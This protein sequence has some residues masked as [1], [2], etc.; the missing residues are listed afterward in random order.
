METTCIFLTHQEDHIHTDT[1]LAYCD[2]YRQCLQVIV[3]L[4]P[5]CKLLLLKRRGSC[6][7]KRKLCVR[8][9][10]HVYV[11]ERKR[12]FCVCM[13]DRGQ[14]RVSFSISFLIFFEAR[15]FTEPKVQLFGYTG[16]SAS[17]RDPSV[18]DH[19]PRVPKLEKTPSP[20]FLEV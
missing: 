7:L 5:Q 14:H 8:V 19:N 4:E 10:V 17:S 18:S 1:W 12:Y 9:C 16:W 20:A 3:N 6:Y 13:Q 15:S 11:C 2:P